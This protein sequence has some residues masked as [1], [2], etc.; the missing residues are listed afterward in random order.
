MRPEFIT[1]HEGETITFD[2]IAVKYHA[3]TNTTAAIVSEWLDKGY[4]RCAGTKKDVIT[5][6]PY[7][8]RT[9]KVLKE[10]KEKKVV[11]KIERPDYDMV[12]I[13]RLHDRLRPYYAEHPKKYYERK[14]DV[15]RLSAWFFAHQGGTAVI[16]VKERAYEIFGREKALDKSGS[17][18][19]GYSIMKSCGLTY[20]DLYCYATVEPYY[21]VAAGEGKF[22]LILENRD[23]WV[24]I[25]RAFRET[26]NNCFLGRKVR[27]LVYGG[28]N[29][30]TRV[31]KSNADIN[32]F[33]DFVEMAGLQSVTWLYAGD[34]DRCGFYIAERFIETNN[35]LEARLFYP[36]YMEMIDKNSLLSVPGELSDDNSTGNYKGRLLD[37]FPENYEETIRK[38]LDD[39][40]RIPQEVLTYADYVRILGGNP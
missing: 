29:Q 22:G 26:Q 35:R 13:M 20:T 3:D 34:I 8:R 15:D 17:D 37:G 1:I 24:S 33:Q 38:C 16:T 9:Y 14:E 30:I 10:K 25:S 12:P 32:T 7:C 5:R 23:P 28:G 21:Y 2:E 11:R 36:I 31:R 18:T 4:I 40:H 39:N 27:Y 6:P 19:A